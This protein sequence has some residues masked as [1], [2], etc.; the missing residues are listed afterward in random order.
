MSIARDPGDFGRLTH[1]D[2]RT[3]TRV[4][5]WHV[6][7]GGRGHRDQLTRRYAKRFG[8]IRETPALGECLN[9]DG[10]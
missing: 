2:A 5:A 8:G 3:E 4:G 9:R 6:D 1:R 10:R 7:Y